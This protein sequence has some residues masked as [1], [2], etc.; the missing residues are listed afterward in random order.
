MFIE[1]ILLGKGY[2]LGG[3]LSWPRLKST[4]LS[5]GLMYAAMWKTFWM[6]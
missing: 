4:E 3:E 1:M 5:A 6:E 2:G